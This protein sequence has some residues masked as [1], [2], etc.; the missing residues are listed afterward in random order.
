MC[1][2]VYNNMCIYTYGCIYACGWGRIQICGWH[3][4]MHACMYKCMRWSLQ[5]YKTTLHVYKLMFETNIFEKHHNM[6]SRTSWSS[7]C[8]NPFAHPFFDLR[9]FLYS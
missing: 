3:A 2:C 7:Q 9:T 6:I 5:V 1:V 8:S 4:C